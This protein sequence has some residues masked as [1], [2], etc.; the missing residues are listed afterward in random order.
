V[1]NKMIKKSMIL[2]LIILFF[3]LSIAQSNP[4]GKYDNENLLISNIKRGISLND[5]WWSM[6]RHDLVHSGYSTAETPETNIVSWY[7]K[8]EDFVYASPAVYEERVFIGSDDGKMY[9]LN[10][11]DGTE[12]WNF[13]TGGWADSS[14]ALYIGS[15]DGNVYCLDADTGKEIWTYST[16][17]SV[18][19]SPA[20]FNGKLYIGS[21]DGNMY[22]LN[23][24]NGSKIWAYQTEDWVWSSPS[25]VYG[26]VY[27]GSGDCKV[28]CLN[29]KNGSKI[30]SYKT[31]DWVD[32]SPAVFDGKV[33]IASY[34]DK[35][36]C[37]DATNGLEIWNFKTRYSIDSSPAVSEGKV[38]IGSWDGFVYCLDAEF[39]TEIWKYHTKERV[40]SSPAIYGGKVY[41]GSGDKTVYC[42]GDEVVNHPPTNPTI[43]GP[44][45]GSA[46]TEYDYIFKS[47]D[48]DGDEIY[49]YIL[50]GDSYV[51]CWDGPHSSGEDFIISHTYKKQDTFKIEAKAKDS[52]GL[53]SDWATFNVTI[54][55]N[56]AFNFR[57][58]LI[59]LLK[60]LFFHQFPILRYLIC[61]K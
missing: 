41:I 27:F 28:Y 29:A 1:L 45:S 52:K 35:V 46:L 32:S 21:D 51:E 22:C 40:R 38:Y 12:I 55:R 43:D 54:P 3:S 25:V 56:D 50:W 49:Y 59:D 36:Y 2:L 31:G 10:A 48:R 47:F 34:D 42:F 30:W 37:L 18:F 57:F 13:S 33:Y 15:W 39:G 19:S 44:R 14:P 58:N 16:N 20:I 5:D 60:E 4:I 24:G 61:Q 26:K 17:D 23:A 9:C 11:E 8:T 53:E 6:F 7:Y